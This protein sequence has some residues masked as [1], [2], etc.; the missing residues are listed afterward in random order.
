MP[1]LII[2]DGSNNLYRAYY[3]IRGLTNSSG[4]ATNAVYG[5]VNMLKKLLKDYQPDALAVAFDEGQETARTSQFADYKKD[6]K[7][8]PDDLSVQIPFIYEALE[9]FRVP[10]MRATEWEAD[11]FIGSLAC[12]ARDR[13]WDVVIATSDKDFFQLVGNGIRLYHTGRE[14]MYDAA[15]VEEAFGLPPEKVV[16]VMAI[17][18]D[19][20]DNIPGVP[21]I[22]EKG[23]K[24]LIQQFGSLDGIYENLDQVKK[25]AQRKALEENKEKALLSRE[26]AQ[27]KCDLSIDI[28]LETL[29]LGDPDRPKLH[30]LF[31]RLEFASLMQEFM[32]DAPAVAREHR[33]AATADEVREF[34]AGS[35]PLAIWLEPATLDGFDRPM[36]AALSRK[37]A[38]SLIV[39]LDSEEFVS[40]LRDLLQSDRTFVAYDAKAQIRRL[41]AAQWP[42]PEKWGDVMLMSYVLNPG[43]PSHAFGNIARD[44]LKTD[45]LVRK[46]VQ[47]TAPLFEI[48]HEIGSTALTPYLPYLGEKSDLVMSLRDVLE[49]ELRRDAALL[50]IYEKIELPLFPVL[51]RMEERGIKIDVG[52]LKS[53]SNT[54]G[55]QIAE[56]ETQIYKAA[57]MEFNLNSPQQLGHILFEKL[58]YPVVKKTKTKSF[59]TNMEVLQELASHGFEVP[60]L[61]LRYRELHKLKSTYIDA[62]PQLV[63]GDGRVHTLFNQAVAATGR[64]SS[65]DPNLQNIPIRTETGREIRKAFVAEAGNVLLAADY[66]QVELRILAHISQDEDLI[67][68]FRRGADI[69]RAT[70]SKMF[71]IPEDELTHDQ[72]R[73]AKTI[74]FGVLYGMSAFRLSNELNIPTNQAKDFIDAYFARY[75]KIQGYLDS[76]LEEARRTGKVTTL[77]GRV[78]YIPEIHNRSFTVRGNAERMATNAPI[79]GTAADL[80]KMAMIALDRNLEPTGARM[81]LT[82]HDEIV[83]ESPEASA[84]QVAGIVKET[85]ET[86]F[87]LAV[88]LAVDAHWGKSWFDAKE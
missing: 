84:A 37:A 64:L 3:A 80:L 67:E 69:H 10:V 22:G 65:S 58:N 87:P 60:Q 28:D 17:W 68:T 13:G 43:L 79:Q 33:L 81:L 31:S 83:I 73:A 24:T 76:T 6:R 71:N 8:M 5:F 52:L 25:A 20:I 82:V 49:P 47:K 59:S 74:N 61:I 14:V 70:A 72:R 42:V 38:E 78:R 30:D 66:S 12:S 57:G 27:I 46:D 86:I 19:A 16:D 77:F 54:M 4:L 11:D 36:A 50:E 29:K 39:P 32:P 23:A 44:R 51:G 85:M 9:G 21:G 56:L 1:S 45:V 63:A 48:D 7:P 2:I 40:A 53:M 41:H 18:G 35:D 26:L 34:A 62:L 55:A 75:P 15:G 88:P